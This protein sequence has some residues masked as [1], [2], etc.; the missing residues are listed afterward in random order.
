MTRVVTW[1]QNVEPLGRAAVAIGVFDGVHLGHRRLIEDTISL[2]RDLGVQAAVVTFDRDPDTVV[3]PKTAAAQLTALP[4]KLSLLGEIGLDL[5]LVIPFTPQMAIATPEQ[6]IEEILLASF[7]LV[8]VEVGKDFHFGCKASGD[9]TT[10]AE[11]GRTHGFPVV[12][13]DL[14]QV[15]DAPITSTRIRTAIA[16]GDV[17][18]ARLLLGRPHRLDGDVV[19]GRGE[20][21]AMGVPTANLSVDSACAIPADGVYAG[22]AVIDGARYAAGISMGVPPTFPAARDRVEAHLLGYSGDLRG[23]RISLEF[24]QRLRDQRRFDDLTSLIATIQ[25]DLS[26]CEALAKPLLG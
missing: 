4:D 11:Y 19:T 13:H 1:T 17:N 5:I 7:P 2:A 20:G 16:R 18:E 6:F 24:I 15:E 9:V 21:A 26:R 3:C 10:L 8:A 22:L 23:K 25:D 12:A 14:L